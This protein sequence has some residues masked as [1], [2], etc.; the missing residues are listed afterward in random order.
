MLNEA[1]LTMDAWMKQFE[2]AGLE[3]VQVWEKAALQ[4]AEREALAKTNI[5]QSNEH[6]EGITFSLPAVAG[7]M[8]SDLYFSVMVPFKQ[9]TQMFSFNEDDVPVELRVQ[10]Q[11]NKSR[12]LAIGQ[13]ICKRPDDFVLPALTASVSEYM[14]FEPAPGF[15]NVG[16][17]KI[18][19]DASMIIND[20]QH[21]RAGIEE[22]LK[23]RPALKDN[24]C[25]VVI[26]YDQGLERSQQMFA[27]INT[28]S[29]KPSKSL[30]ILFDKKN[31]FNSLIIDAI[32]QAGFDDAIEYE[33]TSPGN[34]SAKVWGI[35]G[36][37]KAAE[38][39][40]AVNDRTISEYSDEELALLTTLLT[41]WLVT[42]KTHIPDNF[43][44]L[45]E[46]QNVGAVIEA[47]EN[48]V[49]THAVFLHVLATVTRLAL[50]DFHQAKTLY[51][52]E[53]GP[54]FMHQSRKELGI[55]SNDNTFPAIPKLEFLSG[56]NQLDVEKNSQFW[57]GRI[58]NADGTMNPK[59]NGIKLGAWAVCR[60]LGI[61]T[62]D[63]I[64]AL[65]HDIFGELLKEVG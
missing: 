39:V 41:N 6:Y 2:T 52:N 5:E 9:L 65:N 37:K 53:R 43:S 7:K 38:M 64:E 19:L 10:R 44:K 58:V 13:Y 55:K 18:P 1:D 23:Q 36:V 26:F 49:T 32:K 14:Q 46:I 27:D 11:L 59:S 25:T 3:L 12:A 42:L 61:A 57:L 45:I 31:R 28:N 4:K 63:D 8:G 15:T 16:H 30:S 40:L 33:R 34:Q 22:A 56:I 47:R 60:Q 21:R 51:F 48:K 54:L 24:M 29:V 35:T 50:A 20:G 17:V 62:S